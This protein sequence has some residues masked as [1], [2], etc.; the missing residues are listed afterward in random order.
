MPVKPNKSIYP[1]VSSVRRSIQQHSADAGDHQ[2]RTFYDNR[3]NSKAWRRVRKQGLE[4]EPWCVNCLKDGIY[5]PAKVRDHIRQVM[6]GGD[7][8]D[9]SNHQS[10]CTRCHNQ[11]SAR[12]SH[13]NR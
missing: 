1:W 10:L 5:T 12:E 4:R 7:F 8:F 6:K 3:Y 9:P 13:E 11:K 2:G